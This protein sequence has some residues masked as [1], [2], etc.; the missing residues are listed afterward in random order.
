ERRFEKVH[1]RVRALR[2]RSDVIV[3]EAAE[4]M[5]IRL[6]ERRAQ[7]RG[8]PAPA[9]RF[10]ERALPARVSEQGKGLVVEVKARIADLAVELDH[11]HD[12][13]V[14]GDEILA[15]I[16]ER[17]PLRLAPGTVPAEPAGFAIGERLAGDHS[18]AVRPRQWPA[19]KAD[20][21][22]EAAPD[23]VRAVLPP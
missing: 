18:R 20:R 12:R 17:V 23:T 2:R 8:L 4:R 16:V 7:R 3:N 10:A 5:G 9:I 21:L 22:V 14:C 1:V 15:E 6:L 11:G 13:G 19:I